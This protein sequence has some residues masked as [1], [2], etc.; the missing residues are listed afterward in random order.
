M[1]MTSLCVSLALAAGGVLVAKAEPTSPVAREKWNFEDL[2]RTP[3][4]WPC[5]ELTTGEVKAVWIEGVPFKGKPTKFF[6]YYAVPKAADGKPV[7]AM[8]CIHGGWGTAFRNWVELWS[9]RGYASISMD[10]CGS[11]PL[12]VPGTKYDWVSSGVGGPPGWGGF[13]NVH[14][15]VADQWAYHAVACAVRVHTFLR[16]QP[17]VDAERIGLTGL[18]WGGFLTCLTASVDARFKFAAPVYG[19]AYYDTF[20]NAAGRRKTYGEADWN[21]WLRLW[22]P[23]H[24]VPEIRMP[25]LWLS[26]TNDAHFPYGSLRRTFDLVKTPL[27]IAIRL[28]MN[29]SQTSGAE[30]AEIWAYA[31]SFLRG[32][33]KLPKVSRPTEQGG[34]AEVRFETGAAFR[35]PTAVELNY[36]C[37]DG[38]WVDRKW[39]KSAATFD[40]ESG[41]ASAP[42]PKGVTAWFFNLVLDGGLVVSSR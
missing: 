6:A 36:T 27:D 34:L 19:C 28:R 29:H 1:K 25:V 22:D 21:E 16:A 42:L 5:A 23:K 30:P 2:C 9:E 40:V 20:D 24:Y 26:G 38:K 41:M 15:P 12:R 17:G 13:R 32:G 8:V 4:T 14:D 18:S 37:A 39:E 7:P 11:I 35:A 3:E 10:T 31:D 33:K